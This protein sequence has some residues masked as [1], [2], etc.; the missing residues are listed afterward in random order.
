MNFTPEMRSKAAASR[1]AKMA[2]LK[3]QGGKNII[4]TVRAKD[5][6]TVTF[7]HYKL[8]LAVKLH[9]C[10]CFGWETDPKECTSPK[11]ALFP[12]RKYTRAAHVSDSKA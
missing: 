3:E 10:E 6:G 4:H 9:C 1:K 11:C 5:G 8:S 12:F 2:E 7:D